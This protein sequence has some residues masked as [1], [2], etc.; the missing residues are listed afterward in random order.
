MPRT[1]ALLTDVRTTNPGK[2]DI[3][4]SNRSHETDYVVIGSGIG[5]ELVYFAYPNAPG[6]G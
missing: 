1:S 3:A 4:P 5:G 6:S 2:P